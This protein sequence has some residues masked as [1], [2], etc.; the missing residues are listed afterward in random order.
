VTIPHT[1]THP[2]TWDST[3]LVRPAASILSRIF[4]LDLACF[5]RLE[6][7]PVLAL[8]LGVRGIIRETSYASCWR[9][10]GAQPPVVDPW[11]AL[12]PFA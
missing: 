2:P 4:C 10:W 3:G 11:T 8:G 7:V 1:P 5:T 6:K 12:A 9:A